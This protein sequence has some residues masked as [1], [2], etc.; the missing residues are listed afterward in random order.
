MTTTLSVP[1]PGTRRLIRQGLLV[2]ALAFGGIGSWAALA[3]L[4]GAIIAPGLLKVQGTRKTVQHLEG[5]LVRQIHVRDGDRVQA[6]DPLVTLADERVAASLDLLVQ[7]LDAE[8]ARVARLTAQRDFAERIEFPADLLQRA[9][10]PR[11]AQ[12]LQRERALF[13]AMRN[14]LL[15]QMTLS[16]VQI[17][18]TRE[19]LA[20]VQVQ[21]DADDSAARMMQEEV[22]TYE[23]LLQQ[24]YIAGAAV[25]RLR[26]NHEEYQVRRG[27]RQAAAAQARQRITELE[28]AQA[29]RRND[30]LKDASD[31]MVNASARLG[32]LQERHR[33]VLD[34]VARQSVLAPIAGTV[35]GL[36]VFTLGGVVRPGEPLLDI[37]PSDEGLIVEAQVNLDDVD[38]VHLG[39]AAQVRLSAFNARS[40]PLLDGRLVYLSADKLDSERGDRSF[41]VVHVALPADA[42][43][44]LGP[45]LMQP[46]M[47]AE[48]FL[49]TPPR[50]ALQYLLEPITVSLRR[51]A[52]EP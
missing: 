10:T 39:Q 13:T 20:G 18:Q 45:L 43:Q 12:L 27:E 19:E 24:N 22:Q 32:E 11:V 46:G 17:G 37:V 49:K 16:S 15:Q 14:A 42:R 51:A 36:R 38:Q 8:K 28:L 44:L 9:G 25:L 41:Y 33:A 7:Q 4:D 48:V 29:T 52:R 1:D 31:Q 50:T 47:R 5:G 40:T 26:R 30:Y 6:G 35:V 3:P 34:Q 2:I 21:S 23:T